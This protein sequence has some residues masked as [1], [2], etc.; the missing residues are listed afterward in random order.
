MKILLVTLGLLTLGIVPAQAAPSA[1][2]KMII[3]VLSND[4]VSEAIGSANILEIK[5]SI[6]I[7]EHIF[8]IKYQNFLGNQTQICILKASAKLNCAPGLPGRP[9][10]CGIPVFFDPK[11]I[12][13]R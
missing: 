2:A 13:C 7:R 10:P 12:E 1:E 3:N 5:Q 4:S 8:S 11:T 6:T 9:G